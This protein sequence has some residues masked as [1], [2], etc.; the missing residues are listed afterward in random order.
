VLTRPENF[1]PTKKYPLLV[2]IYE[3]M[4]ENLHRYS[5]PAPGTSI[6]VPRY[7]SNGY[8]VLRPDITY[9]PGYPGESA[10]KCVLPAI[11]AVVDRGYIDPARIGIQGHSWGGYQIAYLVTRTNIFRAACAG[12][13]VSDMISAYG[14]IRW[15]SGAS[16]AFQ[17]EMGQSRIGGPPWERPLQF[18]EN[19]P[20]FWADKVHTPYLSIH[21]DA[22][23]AVPWLQGIE[24]FTALRR[25]G[26]ETYLFNYNNEDHNL[27]NRENQKHWTVH[28]AEFF[29]HHLLGAPRADW[30]EKGV[31]YL[32]RGTR[33]L[34][35][36]FGT[37]RNP[38]QEPPTV[39]EQKAEE[40]KAAA[41]GGATPAPG[42]TPAP[43]G[44][45][46][47]GGGK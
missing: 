16:R 32:E 29:D 8:I 38:P 9:T 3:T 11:Q 43:E 13:A 10:L 44:I 12:A 35:T 33:D 39:E 17:Y 6:N 18:I 37:A 41:A 45:P 7:V 5:S 4:A 46:V 2:Y 19:S 26:R 36:V 27:V 30:M 25:L 24:F 1:D 22:D 42:G 31:P 34:R 28:M 15:G 14:G 40:K 20:I 21:N 23:G 47:P